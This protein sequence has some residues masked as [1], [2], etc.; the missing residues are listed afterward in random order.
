M[1]ITYEM[2]VDETLLEALTA[3]NRHPADEHD[4]LAWV[5]Y[6]VYHGRHELLSKLAK[7]HRCEECM[8]SFFSSSRGRQ[9][10]IRFCSA[11]CRSR[12]HRSQQK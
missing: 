9:D 12:S 1:K 6:L 4:V 7:A 3:Q 10:G 8:I 11:K 2:E 5:G